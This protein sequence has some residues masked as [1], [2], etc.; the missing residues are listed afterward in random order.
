MLDEKRKSNDRWEREMQ[1]IRTE[2]QV[3]EVVNRE[4]RKKRRMN[5][6]I[7]VEEW[8]RYFKDLLGRVNRRKES[9]QT[10]RKESNGE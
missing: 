8:D 5:E 1:N 10:N 6:G 2:S 7:K 3:W 4:R 9:N